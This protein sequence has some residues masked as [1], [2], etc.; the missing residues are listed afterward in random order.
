M[1]DL[2]QISEA[3]IEAEGIFSD[4]E[5]RMSDY[6]MLRS[7]MEG[8]RML[9]GEKAY[10]EIIRTRNQ[11]NAQ[12]LAIPV[13]NRELLTV[14][15]ARSCEITGTQATSAKPIIPEFTRGFEIKIY[16]KLNL[17]NHISEAREFAWQLANGVRSI[18]P[19]LESA[20]QNVLEAKKNT[21]L[22]AVGL[23]GINAV[24]NA[25]QI[26]PEMV[27]QMYA[28]IRVAMKRNLIGGG[29]MY[30]MTNTEALANIL[31]YESLGAGNAKDIESIMDGTAPSAI[32][33]FKHGLANE[34]VQ[35]A[36]IQETHYVAPVGSLGLFVTN[37]SDAINKE[38]APEGGKLYTVYE[39]ILGITW[40][41]LEQPICSDLSASYGSAF[42][43]TMGRRYQFAANFGFFTA[44]SSG[45]E[46]PIVK[47][48]LLKTVA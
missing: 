45:N 20:A 12:Q 22:A 18:G 29:V 8:S 10:N 35:G 24:G 25:Y 33:K 11:H 27:E 37:D 13:L 38:E 41:V 48:E 2:T 31:H 9:V 46:S 26:D 17:N 23:D 28:Y 36:G 1:L 7:F 21:A 5:G 32:G 14:L 47:F 42:K 39:P 34:L 44:Y 15:T 6:G 40:D 3:V 16:P 43:R 30:N 4:F 19:N